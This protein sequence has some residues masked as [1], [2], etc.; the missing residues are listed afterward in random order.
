MANMAIGVDFGGTKIAC[1]LVDTR[2]GQ[3]TETAKKKTKIID[4]KKDVLD[5]LKSAIDDL[6]TETSIDIKDTLGIGIGVAGMID[7]QRGILLSAPNIGVS[8]VAITE[9][10][11]KHYGVPCRLGN[12][13]EVA[14]LGEL[15]FGAGRKQDS[16]VCIFVGTG[17]GCGIIH[18]GRPYLGTSG[19][20]GEIGHTIVVPDG[21]KCGCGG[22][23]CLEAYASRTAVAKEI[24][25]GLERGY[26]SSISDKVDLSNGIIRSKAL[27]GAVSLGDALVIRSV[28]KAAQY[29]GIGLANVANFYNPKR[30]ILG[31]GLV[32]AV[33]LYFE[34]AVKEAKLRVLPVPGR[35][36]DIVKAELGDFAGIIGAGMLMNAK[37]S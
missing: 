7:R 4:D 26:E 12:D 24:L 36:L 23:G 33:D 19:T 2:S 1:G 17:I 5:R 20:A 11:S 18:D 32:E 30:I 16:F 29:M 34:T 3:L 37:K 22:S 27:A 28:V 13:L 35:K 6:L 21:R 15:E 14:A 10:I 31:G 8:Q 25:S 9:P